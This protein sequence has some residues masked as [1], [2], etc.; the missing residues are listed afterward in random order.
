MTDIV[1]SSGRI[2]SRK[3]LI[4]AM[5]GLATYTGA[6]TVLQRFAFIS[7]RGRVP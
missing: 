4:P 3:F 1:G 5:I 6:P 7:N 2:R